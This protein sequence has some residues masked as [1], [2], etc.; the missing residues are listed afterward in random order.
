MLRLHIH[1]PAQQ[2][3]SFVSHRTFSNNQKASGEIP[4]GFSWGNQGDDIFRFDLKETS[5]KV[6]QK[7]KSFKM[8]AAWNLK[9]NAELKENVSV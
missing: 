1:Y 5:V 4:L 8:A 7:Y 9:I 6:T 3:I 2:N